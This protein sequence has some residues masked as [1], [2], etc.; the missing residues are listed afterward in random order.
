MGSPFREALRAHRRDE[1][2]SARRWA[3]LPYDQLTLDM[4]PLAGLPAQEQ[5]IVLIESRA[6]AKR[7]PYHKQKLAFI[8]SNQRH[9]ALEQATRGVAVRYLGGESGY[10]EQLDALDLDAPLL[11]MEA[12]ELELRDELQPLVD[13]G[14]LELHPHEGWLSTDEDFAAAG[15][16]NGPWRMDA[17]YRAI[18]RRTGVLMQKGK[19]EGGRFSFD[20]K[21]REAWRGDPPPPPLPSFEPDAITEEVVALIEEHFGSHPGELRVEHLPVTQ[22]HAKTQWRWFLDHALPHFGPY[23]DA[24]S[25][26]SSSLFHARISG[27]LHLHRLSPKRVVDEVAG[28][29]DISIESREGFVRQVL[30]WREYVRQVHRH[31]DGFRKVEQTN[32]FDAQQDLPPAFWGKP[33]GLGCLDHVVEEVWREGYGHHITRLMVLSN[34]AALL[35]VHP[36]QINEWFW[37]AYHDAFDWV[38][39]PNV[40][41]MGIHALGDLITTKPYI[42]S[43]AYINRMSDYC[44]GCAFN[45]KKDCPIT[46][47]YWAFLDR[48]KEQLVQLGR[49]QRPLWS[50]EK[51]D[52]QR[53]ERDRAV[54]DWVATALA[55]GRVLDPAEGPSG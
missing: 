45:P 34:L 53:R 11:M 44:R 43:G 40:R 5:G 41:G 14:R 29:E 25:V 39:E 22:A 20:A 19:P 32:H 8:L 30:G 6:K 46:S 52:A 21:N 24:M 51:R 1:G 50:L 10:A 13:A 18:R 35:G 36:D 23:Q 28:R 48:H 7:R 27:L 9:F 55:Q 49:M 33:S 42:C 37:V 3:Y 15:P 54:M 12:A 38:V 47:M 4:G 16:T 26:H 17:F 2:S 31:T